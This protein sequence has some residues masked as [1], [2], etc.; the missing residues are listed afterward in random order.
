MTDSARDKKVDRGPGFFKARN[1]AMARS[2]GT[3]QFCGLR[4]AEE[5]HHWAWPDYPSDE[6]IRGNDLIV[7]CNTCHE[8]ATLLRN[9]VRREADFE[10]IR[11]KIRTSNSFYEKRKA[12]SF[13]F[14]PEG[15][16]SAETKAQGEFEYVPIGQRTL[17]EGCVYLYSG[18]NITDDLC[19]LRAQ[20][21]ALE[22][23][24]KAIKRQIEHLEQGR[25]VNSREGLKNATV[26]RKWTGLPLN[27]NLRQLKAEYAALRWQKNET[28]TQMKELES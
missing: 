1:H 5:G 6:D 14:F 2:G 11:E 7:L 8:L 25:P 20:L 23:S 24:R 16:G 10:K 13:W 3:C 4:K 28:I 12:F 26:I 27:A 18:I 22:E 15:K 19:D 17:Q 9:W 21:H